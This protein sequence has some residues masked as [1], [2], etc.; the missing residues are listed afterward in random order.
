MVHLARVEYE[1]PDSG[2]ICLVISHY[3]Q[4][5]DYLLTSGILLPI[6]TYEDPI[7]T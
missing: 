5:Q 6:R 3:K 2:I 1:E 4:I 7:T